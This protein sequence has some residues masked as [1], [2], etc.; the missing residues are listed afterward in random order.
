MEYQGGLGCH[1]FQGFRQAQLAIWFD[2]RLEP[3]FATAPP[4]SKNDTY[5]KSGQHCSENKNITSFT[6]VKSQSLRHPV[7]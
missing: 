2:F 5:F 6:K 4:E 3:Y 7:K 1:V